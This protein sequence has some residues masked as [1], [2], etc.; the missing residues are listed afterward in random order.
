[1]DLIS[2]SRWT[3]AV[4]KKRFIRKGMG[5]GC[6]YESR[7]LRQFSEKVTK[8]ESFIVDLTQKG[9]SILGQEKS[10]RSERKK[11]NREV[12]EG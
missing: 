3:K 7:Q 8:G 1:M 2:K 10:R 11:R 9:T 4:V 12:A 5:A 6:P